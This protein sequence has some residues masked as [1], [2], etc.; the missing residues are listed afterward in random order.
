MDKLLAFDRHTGELAWEYERGP[1]RYIVGA[2]SRQVLIG[3]QHIAAIDVESG[4]ARWINS[5]AQPTGRAI[6]CGDEVFVPTS[7][8]LSRISLDTGRETKPPAFSRD[9]LGNLFAIDGALYSISADS[10]TKYAHVEKT[11]VAAP[12]A[13]KMNPDAMSAVLLPRWLAAMERKWDEALR[14]LDRADELSRAQ[15]DDEMPARIA[16]QRVDVLL[17]LAAES[18][19]AQR[20]DIIERAAAFARRADDRIR[21]GLA[22]SGLLI[23]Q[24]SPEPAILRAL[25]LA[26][27]DGDET[28]RLEQ[29]LDART[30]V[31]LHDR[32]LRAWRDAGPTSRPSLQ[33]AAVDLVRSALADGNTSEAAR[34]AD[35]IDV[36]A[37]RDA[38]DDL[39]ALASSVNT[40]LGNH[41]AAA[42][43]PETAIFYW[44]RAAASAEV[45]PENLSAALQLA[46]AYLDPGPGLLG[47][48]HDSARHLQRI[49]ES[50]FVQ[51]LPSELRALATE[52]GVRTVG[53]AIAE[54]KRRLPEG[55]RDD[56]RRLPGV[57]RD[58][59]ALAIVGQDDIPHS[60][61]LRDTASFLDPTRRSEPFGELLPM[62]KLSQLLGVRV[63]SQTT[64]LTAWSSDLGPV[65]EDQPVVIRDW[66]TLDARPAAIAGMVGVLPAGARI[67]AI[68]Q[69]PGRLMWPSPFIEGDGSQLPQPPVI[70]V[71]GMVVIATHANTL[72]GIP[73][74]QGAHPIWRRQ[75]PGRP[76]S[77]LEVVED[78]LVAIDAG[79]ENLSVLHPG[80]GRIQR[81]YSLLVPSV[82]RV[83]EAQVEE[84]LKNILKSAAGVAGVTEA[85]LDVQTT[86]NF[87]ALTGGVVCRSGESRVVGRDV[88]TGR[89]IW[90]HPFT[91]LITGILA[92][93]DDHF[94]ICRG[95]HRMAIIRADTGA[96][97]KDLHAPGLQIPPLDAVLDP[98]PA[99]GSAGGDRVV[100]F[101]R[102]SNDP[103]RYVLAS[104][105]IRDGDMLWQHELG[106]LAT[107]SKRMM[108]ASPDYIAAVAYEF[109]ANDQPR[110]QRPFA[111][112]GLPTL[113]SARLFVFDKGG[114]RRL[115]QSPF[116]FPV[117]SKPDDRY[118]S[119]LISDVAIFDERIVAR[120]HDGYYV[121]GPAE[122]QAALGLRQP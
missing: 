45:N 42:R 5:D 91:D 32:I 101:T 93:N 99:G 108:R 6:I 87:V 95:R 88:A 12:Q 105:P 3:G 68:G 111:V 115:I 79:A 70:H 103:P 60:V 9:P 66:M 46:A 92:L 84:A 56:A 51:S 74:R 81:Q 11:R 69:A 58:T 43:D 31:T 35:A 85:E 17:N 72:I 44:E 113:A 110:L 7:L 73:A 90:E 24:K 49:P 40:L 52:L 48:P 54:L 29:H 63:S 16:H 13:P 94:G 75:F 89:T 121:L 112:R 50:L 19:L 34:I 109:P 61:G 122:E 100:L 30:T 96:I 8:G 37:D 26:R 62:V 18:E 23:A 53:E 47:S 2:D 59:P 38:P 118:Y 107:V 106:P 33:Q 102:T 36:F 77:R 25:D 120:G 1:A 71:G 117:L 57:L 98:P 114:E 4:T 97:V 76:L 104:F 20:G 22:E 55:L 65:I 116:P 78:R 82:K 21:V 83:K 64:N 27:V 67:C 15:N 10:S 39:R 14:L 41:H 28:M 86:S 80:S 119:G